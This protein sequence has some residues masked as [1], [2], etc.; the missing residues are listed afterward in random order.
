MASFNTHFAVGTV[1]TGIA[2]SLCY[3][4]HLS[5]LQLSVSLW[6]LGAG[7]SLLP[8]VDSDNSLVLKMLFTGLAVLAMAFAPFWLAPRLPSVQLL[9]VLACVFVLVR[10]PLMLAFQK[11]S[12]HRGVF[13]SLLA[14]LFFATLSACFGY[15]VLQQSSLVCWLAAGFVGLGYL[16]HLVLD[17]CFSVDLAN[18][19]IKRSFGTALKPISLEYYGRSLLMALAAAWFVWIGPPSQGPWQ[20]ISRSLAN[21]IRANWT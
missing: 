1:V 6:A 17:E 2:A 4:A 19:S 21:Y 12:R 9:C 5:N 3:E 10:F 14:V 20:S 8:D 16:V 15:R 18:T 7:G 13:H 11:F